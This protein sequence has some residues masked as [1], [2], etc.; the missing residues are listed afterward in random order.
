MRVSVVVCTYAESMYPAFIDAVESV[1]SQTYDDIE[2]VIVVDGTESV[3]ERAAAAY[4]DREKVTVLCNETNVGLSASRNVGIEHATG[5]VIA[6]MDDDAVADDDW[7]AELVSTYEREGVEAVGGKMTPIWVAGAPAF[8]PAEFYWLVGV[9]HRGFPDAGPV[10]NTFGSNISFR[11]DVLAEIGGFDEQLGRKGGR[12][13][14]GEETELA[15]R[16]RTEYGGTLYYNPEA[17]VGHKVFEYRTRFRWLLRRAFWQGYSKRVMNQLVD[18]ADG[19][20]T[21]FLGRLFAE[22]VPDRLKQLVRS[23]TKAKVL[24]LIAIF[25]FTSAVGSGYVYAT[26][27]PTVAVDETPAADDSTEENA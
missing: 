14:Q 3:Y 7:V 26:V 9:T 21:A 15:A 2:L 8:L 18:S 13:V 27:G 24:Q 25:V 4:G 10:R 12:Q 17:T 5:D 1:L 16:L 6:F 11:A 23:P 19:N 20:E 22:F